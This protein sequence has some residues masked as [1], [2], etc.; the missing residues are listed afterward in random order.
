MAKVSPSDLVASSNS[1]GRGEVDADR[2]ED[3]EWTTPFEQL[4]RRAW[5]AEVITAVV[6]GAVMVLSRKAWFL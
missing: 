2:E 3:E 4:V 1:E 6:D 5:Q